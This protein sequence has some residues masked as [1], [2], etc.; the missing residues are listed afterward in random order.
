MW[1][2]NCTA[3]VTVDISARKVVVVNH[4]DD[5][6]I[7]DFAPVADYFMCCGTAEGQTYTGC[8]SKNFWRRANPALRCNG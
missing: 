2:N 8:Y 3:G 5:W 4:S 6:H 1:K 7:V